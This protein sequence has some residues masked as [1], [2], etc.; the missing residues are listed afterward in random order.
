MSSF[1]YEHNL[2]VEEVPIA[3]LTL[4]RSINKTLLE[5]VVASQKLNAMKDKK[6]LV[7]VSKTT[8]IG[9]AASA[10]ENETFAAL[11]SINDDCLR[12]IFSYLHIIDVTHLAATCTRLNNFAEAEIFPKK[13]KSICI[14]IEN[15]FAP[16]TVHIKAPSG[17]PNSLQITPDE[18]KTA[19][20]YFGK[21]VD[22]LEIEYKYFWIKKPKIERGIRI[23]AL[24]LKKCIN[25]S[26]L[27]CHCDDG[28]KFN[29]YQTLVF[30]EHI[31]MLHN[32][33]ELALDNC[34]GISR[35]WPKTLESPS[36]VEKFL[37]A[38]SNILRTSLITF[39][40]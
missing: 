31:E 18:L 30:M 28:F 34:H 12:K 10:S 24:L 13:A 4:E 36:K 1:E 37:L 25:L 20:S 32:L 22:D 26:I 27:Y 39:V 15:Y 2:S 17:N 14:E 33:K 40:I 19:L 16:L 8:M 35:N 21:F 9:N 7:D 3:D 5:N 38:T 11:D 23:M 6:P 29:P